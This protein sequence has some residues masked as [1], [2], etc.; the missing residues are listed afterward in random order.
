MAKRE[1]SLEDDVRAA[2][3]RAC[4]EQDLQVAEYLLQALE[5]L[6][7]RTGDDDE[8]KRIYLSITS[9]FHKNQ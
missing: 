6:V 1:C 3:E 5:T 2:L 9:S 7:R 8:L 4:R